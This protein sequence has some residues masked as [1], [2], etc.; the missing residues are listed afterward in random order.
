M[1]GLAQLYLSSSANAAAFTSVA[2]IGLQHLSDSSA[3][4]GRAVRLPHLQSHS[5]AHT[6]SRQM[7][8]RILPEPCTYTV[9]N[10]ESS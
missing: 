10:C 5:A 7:V 2:V 9:C 6:R 1:V 8:G 3:V 4:D